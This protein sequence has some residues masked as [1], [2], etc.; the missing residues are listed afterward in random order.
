[1]IKAGC[2]S[3]YSDSALKRKEDEWKSRHLSPSRRFRQIEA[4]MLYCLLYAPK[5]IHGPNLMTA[6]PIETSTKLISGDELLAMGD[7]G[8]CELIDGEIVSMGPTGGVRSFLESK[9]DRRLG[10]FIENTKSG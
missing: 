5:G 2:I 10:A 1:M 7:S 9:L 4:G 3:D 8:P 6:P